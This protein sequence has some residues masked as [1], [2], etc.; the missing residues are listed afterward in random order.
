M[1]YFQMFSLLDFA[2]TT[3]S[4]SMLSAESKRRILKKRKTDENSGGTKRI[5]GRGLLKIFIPGI[6]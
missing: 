6:H 2:R 5:M 1:W 3:Y 4:Y